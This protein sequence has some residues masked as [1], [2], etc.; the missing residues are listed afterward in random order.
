MLKHLSV[1]LALSTFI[2]CSSSREFKI[3]KEKFSGDTISSLEQTIADSGFFKSRKGKVY[4]V[5]KSVDTSIAEG[6]SLTTTRS[7][8]MAAPLSPEAEAQI[9]LIFSPESDNPVREQAKTTKAPGARKAFSSTVKLFN[10]LPADDIMDTFNI[11]HKTTRVK[12]E[13]KN[14][15]LK[16]VYIYLIIREDDNDYHMIIGDKPNYQDATVRFN[17][18]ISGLPKK[19]PD[20][21]ITLKN[22]RQKIAE[23]IGFVPK[24]A[25]NNNGTSIPVKISGSLFYDAHHKGKFGGQG[26]IK[27]TT[28]WEIHPVTSITFL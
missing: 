11:G 15:T 12:P 1:A 28:I 27:S 13:E 7:V 3:Y 25:A 6:L 8:V 24:K 4:P 17:A 21:K 14:I 22:I 18:E 9:D 5:F 19:F 23:N 20:I 2:A 10:T 16:K 26:K